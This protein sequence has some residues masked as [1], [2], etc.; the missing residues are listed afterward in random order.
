MTKDDKDT[1][2]ISIIGEA[3]HF[4]GNKKDLVKR[5]CGFDGCPLYCWSSLLFSLKVIQSHLASLPTL[6]IHI[7][8]I[9]LSITQTAFFTP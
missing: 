6:I 8:N 4:R 5:E 1:R 3:F 9:E 7:I 2:A